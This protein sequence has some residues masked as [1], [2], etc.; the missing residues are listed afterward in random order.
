MLDIQPWSRRTP[1]L[2]HYAPMASH[3][4]AF[5]AFLAKT[6]G[7]AQDQRR[8]N[9]TIRKGS[10]IGRKSFSTERKSDTAGKWNT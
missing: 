2:Y 1:L 6:P 4:I 8:P 10:K 9:P 3:C 7:V 5:L